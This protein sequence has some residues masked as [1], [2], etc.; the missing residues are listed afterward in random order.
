MADKT[1]ELLEQGLRLLPP[2]FSALAS[3]VRFILDRVDDG[4]YGAFLGSDFCALL[5]L[6]AEGFSP[7]HPIITHLTKAID[8]YLWEDSKGLRM[9]FTHGPLWATGLMAL[10]LLDTGLQTA[11]MDRKQS[12]CPQHFILGCSTLSV[13]I[14]WFKDHKILSV[15]GDCHKQN[16]RLALGGWC[17]QECVSVHQDSSYNRYHAFSRKQYFPVFA[18]P[19]PEYSL[20][21]QR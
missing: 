17:Y 9:Q 8:K 6:R 16:S 19:C 21:R 12:C 18:D 20:P 3:C 13:T 2:R 5:T 4:G 11:A 1:L 15:P 10:G 7:Q 14:E